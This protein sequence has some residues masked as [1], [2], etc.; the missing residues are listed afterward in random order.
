MGNLA[1]PVQV[2]NRCPVCIG[3]TLGNFRGR[4]FE[5]SVDSGK[6]FHSLLSR[7]TNKA[8][9]NPEEVKS[10]SVESWALGAKLFILIT[11]VPIRS[12]RK[13]CPKL[14][15]IFDS[16][17]KG[18]GADRDADVED[19]KSGS[20][21]GKPR[22][23]D[24]LEGWWK[25]N[26]KEVMAEAAT[27][28]AA[29]EKEQL[30]KNVRLALQGLHAIRIKVISGVPDTQLAAF[31]FS[32]EKGSPQSRHNF[33]RRKV[34]QFDALNL[35]VDPALLGSFFDDMPPANS[36][37]EELFKKFR[38]EL[39]TPI[40]YWSTVRRLAE[41]MWTPCTSHWDEFRHRWLGERRTGSN[42]NSRQRVN[43]RRKTQSLST[44][45]PVAAADAGDL[46][47]ALLEKLDSTLSADMKAQLAR[48][49]VQKYLRKADP[50][51]P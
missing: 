46:L 48:A 8:K 43:L 33:V 3:G 26:Q 4:T 41:A 51:K 24:F 23:K 39:E 50:P 16:M 34:T 12:A 21:Q 22:G 5:K 2:S 17:A 49:M 18:F 20:P 11:V 6:L 44:A 28:E 32:H 15:V 30:G 9:V 7:F 47:G 37:V 45:P 35:A 36:P 29:L 31:V 40:S 27:V 13:L 38:E 25:K 1:A 14:N 10:G 19:E 42:P